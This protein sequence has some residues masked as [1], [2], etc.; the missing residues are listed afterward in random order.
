MN[1]IKSRSTEKLPGRNLE[2]TATKRQTLDGEKG[3][4]R[5]GEIYSPDY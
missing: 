1:S 2:Q 3:N 5:T 4:R